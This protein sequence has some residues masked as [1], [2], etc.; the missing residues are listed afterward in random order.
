MD[1]GS[2][3]KAVLPVGGVADND[4][5][6]QDVQVVL[7]MLRHTA[8]ELARAHAEMDLLVH[9]VSHDLREPLRM[10]NAYAQLLARR[11]AGRLDA[12][13]DQFLSYMA[14]GAQRM[15]GLA[16]DLLAYGK[17]GRGTL[18]RVTCDSGAVLD[19]ALGHVA[20]AIAESHAI[21]RAGGM[22]V[23]VADPGALV[24]LFTNLL[25]NAVRYRH[26]DRRPDIE[27]VGTEVEG[28]WHFRVTDNGLSV[29][30]GEVD[31]IFMVFQR[32]HGSER[33]GTGLGLPIC[34][35]IVERHGGRIWVEPHP[36]A[37]GATFHFTLLR[38]L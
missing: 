32:L 16:E 19:E 13:A 1:N 4:R 25:D 3:E 38:L 31:R 36:D 7:S 33:P 10:V 27:V 12:D 5:P 29:P 35:R 34:K 8:A 11:Y 17:L 26:P 15:Q 9:A 20:P 22:P 18:N 23:V 14:D 37:H 30:Q 21:V 28:G 2:A 6:P 24:Q